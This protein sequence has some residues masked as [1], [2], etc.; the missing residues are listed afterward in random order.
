[1]F[2]AC[3]CQV[4]SPAASFAQNCSRLCSGPP[5]GLD[6]RYLSPHLFLPSAFT[7]SRPHPRNDRWE[8]LSPLLLGLL[9]NIGLR[10]QGE[11]CLKPN[12]TRRPSHDENSGR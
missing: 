6:L 1:M 7:P 3:G 2:G 10:P 11:L 12:L 9:F 4:F 5:Q 8:L